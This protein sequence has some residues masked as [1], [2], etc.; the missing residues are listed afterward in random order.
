MFTS[1]A[2]PVNDP[3]R[4]SCRDCLTLAA[5]VPADFSRRVEAEVGITVSDGLSS[6]RLPRASSG[7]DVSCAGQ[8]VETSYGI[9]YRHFLKATDVRP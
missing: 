8:V 5:S 3:L 7:P 1:M 6:C 9:D 4:G 2:W